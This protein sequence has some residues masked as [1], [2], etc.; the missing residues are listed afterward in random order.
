MLMHDFDP[1]VGDC[2]RLIFGQ[3]L[4]WRSHPGGLVR[5]QGGGQSQAAT[6]ASLYVLCLG[7]L[8]PRRPAWR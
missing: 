8:W 4:P 1:F 2:R 6:P 7:G 5:G 3:R